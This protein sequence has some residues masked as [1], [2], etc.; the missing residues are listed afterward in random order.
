MCA[1]AYSSQ[2]SQRLTPWTIDPPVTKELNQL[3]GGA[4]DSLVSVIKQRDT[5]ARA[6]SVCASG[7][8]LYVLACL[9]T[10]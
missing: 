4:T 5:H 1:A 9:S 10:R 6:V 3:V 8:I 7:S 2:L